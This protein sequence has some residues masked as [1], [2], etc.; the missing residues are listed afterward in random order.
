M[1][2]DQ[3]IKF[4]DAPN[5]A[6]KKF[7]EKFKEIDSLPVKDWSVTHLIG[8][9][10]KLYR[11]HYNCN[12]K[13]KYNTTAPSKCF[14]VFQVKKLGQN[15]SSDPVL[16]KKYIEW[17]FKEKVRIAKRKITSI[18]FL[19]HEILVSEYKMKYLAGELQGQKIDRTTEIPE[20]FMQ[21][22]RKYNYSISTY[23]ELSFLLQI[24]EESIL[25]MQREL[26]DVGLDLNKVK[27]IS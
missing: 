6:Y 18:A 10:C 1:K 24:E 4:E 11:D 13:F 20:E 3:N 17:A 2:E 5:E 7:F 14:E 9:F 15:L 27:K 22:I 8:H 16:L 25:E 12:Y 26:S 19:A 23:G 21:V